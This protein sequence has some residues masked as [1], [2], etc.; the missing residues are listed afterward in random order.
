MDVDYLAQVVRDSDQAPPVPAKVDKARYLYTIKIVQAENLP[1]LSTNGFND[2]YCV[3]TDEE[4][5]GLART[6]VIYETLN[7][8]WNEAFNITIENS[9]KM[10]WLSV[11]VWDRDQIGSDEICGKAYIKL[12]PSYFNDFLAHDVWL[13]LDPHGRILL[14]ISMEGEKDDIQFYFGK[15]FRTLKRAH[16]DM[17]R[18]IVDRVCIHKFDFPFCE[19]N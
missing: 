12:D 9:D 4:G 19:L 11:T 17:A 10:R 6:R 8:H 2:P 5:N 14:R 16:D 18:I 1:A 13:D 7:P 15:A 3:L